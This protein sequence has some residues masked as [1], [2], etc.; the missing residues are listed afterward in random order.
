MNPSIRRSEVIARTLTGLKARVSKR[1]GRDVFSGIKIEPTGSCEKLGSALGGWV[2]PS[3]RLNEDSICYCVGVGEDMTFD[4]ALLERFRCRVFS[5]DPTPRAIDHAAIVARDKPALLFSPIGVWDQ[6]EI[7][8]FYAPK[9]PLHV[10]HSVLNLQGTDK[11][12][13]AS[14]KKLRSIM[15]ENGH[16]RIDLLKLDVEGAEYRILNSIFRDRLNIDVI[17]V[18][19]DEIFHPLD[20][21]FKDRINSMIKKIILNGYSLANIDG[22][23][24]YTFVRQ[25]S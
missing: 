20:K 23:S 25:H 5:F 2:I 3:G 4:L 15:Q 24:N 18:E 19:F 22:I 6:D 11:F 21:S 14:C 7:L 9:N 17:C 13:E 1:F 8:R 16:D 10:S 12:F